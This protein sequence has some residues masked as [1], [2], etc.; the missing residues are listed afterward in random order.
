[1]VSEERPAP[2]S[3]GRVQ[4]RLTTARSAL[5][6]HP[7]H[8]LGPPHSGPNRSSVNPIPLLARMAIPACT[9]QRNKA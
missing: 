2:Q 8:S 7:R 6:Q 1:M 5:L 3:D 9:I 4:V